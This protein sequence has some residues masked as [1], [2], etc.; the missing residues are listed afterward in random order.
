MSRSVCWRIV[1]ASV[2]ARLWALDALIS[3]LAVTA[4]S[5]SAI[6]ATSIDRRAIHVPLHRLGLRR[7]VGRILAG[8]LGQRR[9]AG[10]RAST[11]AAMRKAILRMIQ[12]IHLGPA[13]KDIL[14]EAHLGANSSKN[15]V[16]AVGGNTADEA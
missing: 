6:M 9:R 8:V 10:D 3:G 1:S 5:A 14:S 7:E 4:M 13:K 11:S 2:G 15:G 12:P 16:F